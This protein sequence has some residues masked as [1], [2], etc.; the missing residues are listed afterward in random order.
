MGLTWRGGSKA[1][2]HPAVLTTPLHP[3]RAPAPVSCPCTHL[4]AAMWVLSHEGCTMG[5]APPVTMPPRCAGT[6]CLTLCHW[7]RLWREAGLLGELGHVEAHP[8]HAQP[9]PSPCSAQPAMSCCHG[10]WCCINAY[11]HYTV[12]YCLGMRCILNW[13]SIHA[14]CCP[15]LVLF[16]LLCITDA[17]PLITGPCPPSWHHWPMSTILPLIAAPRCIFQDSSFTHTLPSNLPPRFPVMPPHTWQVRHVFA[18][19]IEEPTE[20]AW[21]ENSASEEGVPL[22]GFVRGVHPVCPSPSYP[23]LCAPRATVCPLPCRQASPSSLVSAPPYSPLWSCAHLLYHRCSSIL[24]YATLFECL[25]GAVT[26]LC[27][28]LTLLASLLQPEL[29]AGEAPPEPALCIHYSKSPSHLCPPCSCP[30][31]PCSLSLL[32]PGQTLEVLLCEHVLPL[33]ARRAEERLPQC[34][35][36]QTLL[37]Q[38]G[39]SVE[40]RHVFRCH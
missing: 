14:T 38:C 31:H 35:D 5:V 9:M 24:F 13:F 32:P 28:G 26:V 40:S 27:P 2:P 33:A 30:P 11:C 6:T 18:E 39:D 3:Y 20:D 12:A 22:C 16:S 25:R 34:G 23:P 29:S 17:L 10:L 15:S 19:C 36:S 37:P 8:I 21:G 4:L 7:Y 1:P